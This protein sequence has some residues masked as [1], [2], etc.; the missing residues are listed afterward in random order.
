MHDF[1][2]GPNEYRVTQINCTTEKLLARYLGKHN[3]DVKVLKILQN[4]AHCKFLQPDYVHTL[5]NCST[6]NL[7]IVVRSAV[8]TNYDETCHRAVI[9]TTNYMFAVQGVQIGSRSGQEGDG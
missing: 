5:F 4:K 8:V 9:L 2:K 3:L 6:T 7:D 1:G